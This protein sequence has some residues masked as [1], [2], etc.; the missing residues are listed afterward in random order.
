MLLTPQLKKLAVYAAFV[1]AVM[2]LLQH[3]YP[4]AHFTTALAVLALGVQHL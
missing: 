2:I 3:R 4:S 1:A